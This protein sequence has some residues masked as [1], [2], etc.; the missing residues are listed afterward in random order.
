MHNHQFS[1]LIT[2]INIHENGLE[3]YCSN[4]TVLQFL[5]VNVINTHQRET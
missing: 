1:E 5:L 2:R 4:F 3:K